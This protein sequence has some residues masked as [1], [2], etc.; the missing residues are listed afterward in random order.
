MSLVWKQQA[1]DN[2]LAFLTVSLTLNISV[3]EPGVSWS[4]E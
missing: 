1:Q 4:Q 2:T 3:L